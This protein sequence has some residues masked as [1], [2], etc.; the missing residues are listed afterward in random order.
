[1]VLAKLRERYRVRAF[2]GGEAW[3]MLEE[4]PETEPVLSCVPGPGMWPSFLLRTTQDLRQLRQ[5][6]PDLLVSDGDGPSMH[7]ARAL[8]IPSV[9]VGHGLIFQ[10]AELGTR[11]PWRKHWREVANAMSSSWPARR[12]VAVHFA[13]AEPRTKGTILARPDLPASLRPSARREDFVLAYFRDDNGS[14]IMDRLVR[15][16]HRVLCFGRSTR[17]PSGVEAHPPSVRAFAEALG[18]C[19]A[20]V[21]SAGNHL[22]AECALLGLPMLALYRRGDAEQEMNARLVEAGGIGV[23]S[24][25]EQASDELIRR[26][27]AELERPR[28]ALADKTRAMTPASEAIPR[29]IREALSGDTSV[30]D[31]A[32]A[33]C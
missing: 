15:R 19:R 23:A 8:G 7:A 25:I 21:G 26:F 27:E 17:I 14:E 3:A 13:P 2:C 20:V 29:T 22:P 16:G 30:P 33:H 18:R 9:A 32:L 5:W 28:Q 31:I 12:R 11:L 6:T 1:M 4:L 24:I 10:H